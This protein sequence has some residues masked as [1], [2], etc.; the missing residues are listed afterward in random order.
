MSPQTL[1][2]IA[3]RAQRTQQAG[4]DPISAFT[5]ERHASELE[6]TLRDMEAQ[7]MVNI[8]G[9]DPDG[10]LRWSAA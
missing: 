10:G 6:H 9:V 1:L 3:D 7:G 8:T 5:R 4:E 2:R